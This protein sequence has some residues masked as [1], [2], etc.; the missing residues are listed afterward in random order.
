MAN[1]SICLNMI[2]KNEAHVIKDTLDNL[3]KYIKFSYYVISDTGS[4]DDT[5]KIITNFFKSKNVK[6]KI[7]DDEWKDF[8]YNRSLALKYAN[9][10]QHIAK[11]VFIFD[12]DDRIH[13]TMHLPVNISHDSYYLKFGSGVQYKRV[14]LVNN[15]LEW[16][17]IGVLH[18]YINCI[19][20]NNN[21]VGMIDGDYY[22]DSGKS[23]A[24]SKDPDKYKKDALVLEK[25]FYEEEKNN[26]RLKVR[27]AFYCA[28]SYRDADDKQNALKWYMKRAELKDWHEEVFFSYYM[29]GKIYRDMN[30]MEKAIYY[31]TLSYDADKDR[32]EG[33]YEIIT[34][35]RKTNNAFLAYKYFMMIS[36]DYEKINNAYM[37]KLFVYYPVYDFLLDYEMSLIY[38]N[39]GNYLSGV[40]VHKKLFINK[41]MPIELMINILENFAFYLK[42]IVYDLELFEYYFDFV[43]KIYLI[44]GGFS[45]KH[46]KNIEDTVDKIRSLTGDGGKDLSIIKKMLGSG[47]GNSTCNSTSSNSN[48]TCNSTNIFFSITTCKRY[49]LFSKTMNSFLINCKDISL[50]N[51]FFCVDD[52]SSHE[53]R[54]NMITNY[55][56]LKFYLKK[57]EEKGHL[58]SMNIIWNKLKELKPKYWIHLEDDWLFIKPCNYIQKSID[59]LEKQGRCK[60]IHQV[61]FN[62]NYAEVINNY[63]IVG[64]E[65]MGDFLL[66]IKDEPNLYGKNCAYW[67]HYSFRPSM[68][69]AETIIK[70]GNYMSP[71]TFFEMDYALKYYNDGAGYKSAFFNEITC[72]HIGK[73][74]SDKSS[75]IPNAYVLNDIKQFAPDDKTAY[76]FIY[77]NNNISHKLHTKRLFLNNNFKSSK[78]IIHDFLKHINVWKKIL[79]K[80]SNYFII[81]NGKGNGNDYSK[82]IDNKYDI[83]L[84]SSSEYI[85]NKNAVIK[86]LNYIDKNSIIEPSLKE[87]FISVNGFGLSIKQ[88]EEVLL[89]NDATDATDDTD[90]TDATD[91][92][93]ECYDLR[94]YLD[95]YEYIFIKNKDHYGDDITFIKEKSINELMLICDI[96]DDAI[97]FN[98]FGFVKN[99]VDMDN[100]IDVNVGD[101]GIYINTEKYYNKYKKRINNDSN[102]IVK[103]VKCANKIM[104]DKSSILDQHNIT[105]ESMINYANNNEICMGFCQG[106]V[107][108]HTLVISQKSDVSYKAYI[109]ISMLKDS[110]N[111]DTFIN[112]NRYIK[113]NYTDFSI[114][115]N[116]N[117][118]IS[119]IGKYI[120]IK[121]YDY[122]NNDNDID[123][124]NNLSIYEM[125]KISDSNNNCMGFNTLGFFK[126]NIDV[127]N[128][129]KCSCGIFIKIEAVPGEIK[130]A[131]IT[132]LDKEYAYANDT[133]AVNS[134]GFYKK[135]LGDIIDINPLYNNYLL[136]DINKLKCYKTTV[137]VKLICSWCSS[138][139]LCKSMNKMSMGS[140]RW[141]NLEFVCNDNLVDYYVIFKEVFENTYYDPE[142]TIYFSNGSDG[143]DGYNGSDGSD[144]IIDHNI[145]SKFKPGICTLA[146][147]K[148]GICTLAKCK[149]Y[150]W[151]INKTYF[152]LKYDTIEKKYNNV[153]TGVGD[154]CDYKYVVCETLDQVLDA[155][156]CECACI[157]KGNKN[158]L[159][160]ISEIN[161]LNELINDVSL[162]EQKI[163]SI[164][165]IKNYI[166]DYYNIFATIER[167]IS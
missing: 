165:K 107:R 15:M 11:Y 152:D 127:N 78:K 69:I 93:D 124:K 167:I 25:A 141:N 58:A 19:S 79:G 102:V 138:E 137:R 71:N 103:Y 80:A 87:L 1:N 74:T 22:I 126:T 63:D 50:I 5:K 94:Y 99:V 12:A 144:K 140:L 28:Q 76:E 59:F 45:E 64:G 90:A 2:V 68:C 7:Y 85:I 123:Y 119:F 131:N 108:S 35:F 82:M 129:T 33:I 145:I 106:S 158:N 17:F 57:E 43:R 155:T 111:C 70:L 62:K 86:I 48:S 32:Y 67:P 10:C 112:I 114:N 36:S 97:A 41:S 21:N 109:N 139:D 159:S 135:E 31:W 83:I 8:G 16:N 150:F 14:L 98:T 136:V 121:G 44:T 72:I 92:T 160:E 81:L 166:L 52:N 20:K 117:F 125:M 147:F 113:T 142:K 30:E 77:I 27:Y 55:P 101:H 143:S 4:T 134:Y 73:L 66:H 53:D 132:T 46:M 60:R 162:W 24:R 49:D 151:N 84:I 26:G 163:D 118:I 148:P 100:L 39:T 75:N 149:P 120:Y 157:Y 156:I 65:K 164:K 95:S 47:S 128:L 29:I 38:F 91:A 23:G 34:H 154:I 54:K 9:K 115:N 146:K 42:H 88:L 61:L 161:G 56:F 51:Y 37:D 116:N 104:N 96:N 122:F 130:F 105:I 40:A 6:G 18:E 3:W 153:F 133:V 110:D 13:G 89:T